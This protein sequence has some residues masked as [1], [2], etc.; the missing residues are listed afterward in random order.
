M[1]KIPKKQISES[2]EDEREWAEMRS[3]VRRGF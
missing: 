2:R 3:G 1:N